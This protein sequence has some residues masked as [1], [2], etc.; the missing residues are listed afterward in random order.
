VTEL[1]GQGV[2]ARDTRGRVWKL[3]A[4]DWVL[5]AGAQHRGAGGDG[6][7]PVVWLG[8]AGQGVAV[9][10]LAE[11][12]RE[13]AAE[14]L[15]GLQARGLRVGLLSGDSP[16]RA[17]ALARRVGVGE[18]AA[19]LDPQ[20]KLQAVRG[21]QAAGQRVAMVG[22]GLNDA[23]VLAASDVSMAMGHGALAARQGADAVIVSGRLAGVLDLAETAARTRSVVRQNMAWAVAYNAACIP[24]AMVGWMPPWAAGLGMA[25]SSLLV[26]LNAQRAGRQPWTSSTC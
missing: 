14:A 11:E 6:S 2:S 5:D 4:A 26:I 23:P 15:R 9:F 25:A 1:P 12:L 8:C 16:G 24:L 18:V 21:A 19:G 7:G 22:D 17:H 13:D 3:G 20:G 10:E